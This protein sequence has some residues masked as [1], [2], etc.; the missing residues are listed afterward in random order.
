MRVTIVFVMTLLTADFIHA[1]PIYRCDIDGKHVFQN[2]PCPSAAESETRLDTD[3]RFMTGVKSGGSAHDAD[4]GRS[5]SGLTAGER[6][7]LAE[8]EAREA[9]NQARRDRERQIYG[10][11]LENKVGRGMTPE[12]VRQSWGAPAR[13][14]SRIGSYGKRE[15][16][17]YERDGATQYVYIDNGKVSS[18]STTDY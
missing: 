3:T 5:N 10:W 7:L 2:T 9:E 14:N 15:Q 17:V 4:T 12:H 16:W 18:V 13:V 11:I 6:E 8:A 1:A